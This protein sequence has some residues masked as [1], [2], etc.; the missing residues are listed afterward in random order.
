MRWRCRWAGR[1]DE[2]RLPTLGVEVGESRGQPAAGCCRALVITVQPGG[3]AERA[4]ILPTGR[5]RDGALERGDVIVEVEDAPVRSNN[6]PVLVL[7]RRS[8]G[9][10]V[11]VGLLRAGQE[12]RV[13]VTLEA[14]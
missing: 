9:D 12:T 3:G 10:P 8:A 6:D 1:H 11:E 7:E 2:M 5:G 14:T 13:Q 4:G